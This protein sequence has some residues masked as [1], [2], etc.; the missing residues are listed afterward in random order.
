MK[1]LRPWVVTVVGGHVFLAVAGWG[2]SLGGALGL[3]TLVGLP[4]TGAV[5]VGL[6]MLFHRAIRRAAAPEAPDE[7]RFLGFL[8]P[9]VI[10]FLRPL[11]ELG[12]LQ[13]AAGLCANAGG[14]RGEPLRLVRPV[15]ALSWLRVALELFAWGS[16]LSAAPHERAVPAALA[17]AASLFVL[18]AVLHLV[19]QPLHERERE[20]RD[21]RRRDVRSVGSEEPVA[22]APLWRLRAA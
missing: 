20:R 22:V 2:A 8:V 9:A 21:A 15:A 12:L 16:L 5:G 18:A 3:P 13:S 11:I 6:L 14:T 10:P 4:L 17:Q 19:A 7:A 1:T